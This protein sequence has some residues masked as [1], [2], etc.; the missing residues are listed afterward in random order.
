MLSNQ[1]LTAVNIE[2]YNETTWYNM[3][4]FDSAMTITIN[5]SDQSRILAEFSTSVSLSNS[6]VW[7]RIVIDNQ[8]NSTVCYTSSVPAMNLPLQSKILTD[9][10]SAGEHT[11][12]VQFYRVSG[13]ST[14]RDRLLIVSEL[15]A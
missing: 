10:L 12:E 13:S 15:P 8:Y 3:T 5:T 4:E 2:S 1:N 7:F 14:I 6:Q 9:S 11:I